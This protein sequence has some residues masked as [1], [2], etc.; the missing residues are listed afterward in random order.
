MLTLPMAL[1]LA[2]P[3]LLA[4]IGAALAA[5]WDA[6]AVA[7]F[8]IAALTDW[9]DGWAARRWGLVTRAGAMADHAA[10]KVL[11]VGALLL[12]AWAGRLEA[13]YAIAPAV[14]IA[15]R[16]F[17]VLALRAYAPAGAVPVGPWGKAKTAV[18]MAALAALFWPPL[19]PAGAALL[20][21]AR[22]AIC[23]AVLALPQ[24]P[25]GTA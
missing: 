7:L 16:E 12:L 4:P 13:L 1:T 15:A 17:A 10:D 8:A 5:G 11:V 25:T 21:A 14:I 18:Q 20:W 23:T 22:A 3:A 2:R 9:A 19:A 24:G 6:A